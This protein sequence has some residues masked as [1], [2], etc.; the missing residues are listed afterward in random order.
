MRS[1]KPVVIYADEVQSLLQDEQFWAHLSEVPVPRRF[2]DSPVSPAG[3]GT[4]RTEW[5]PRGEDQVLRGEIGSGLPQ[6]VSLASTMLPML[7]GRLHSYSV[8]RDLVKS[9]QNES[10]WVQGSVGSLGRGGS[11]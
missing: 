7:P 3:P 9:V 6:E 2:P 5:V 11:K 10:G 1:G 4:T 8:K